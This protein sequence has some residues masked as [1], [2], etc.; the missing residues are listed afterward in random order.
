M[1]VFLRSLSESNATGYKIVLLIYRTLA[2][3]IFMVEDSVAASRKRELSTAMTCITV[4]S[5]VLEELHA[6]VTGSMQKDGPDMTILFQLLRA[7]PENPGWLQRWTTHLTQ[8]L[9]ARGNPDDDNLIVL[10]LS[11][12]CVFLDW[13]NLK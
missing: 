4:S 6:R 3:D 13:T 9:V 10:I 5:Q 11:V 2:E 7:N 12:L 8:L 1:D